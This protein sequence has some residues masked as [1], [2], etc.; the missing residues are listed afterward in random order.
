MYNLKKKEEKKIFKKLVWKKVANLFNATRDRLGRG[1]AITKNKRSREKGG[2][3]SL[4]LIDAQWKRNGPRLTSSHER[5]AY[6]Y[7][8]KWD[9]QPT[10]KGYAFS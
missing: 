1:H 7:Q 4:S 9:S 8:S 2:M 3:K 6:A 5:N 10:V